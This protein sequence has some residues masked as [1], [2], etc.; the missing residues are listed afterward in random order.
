MAATSLK[1]DK[2]KVELVQKA[3]LLPGESYPLLSA[4]EV[5]CNGK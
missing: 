4:V 3:G 5:D 1:E 2:K